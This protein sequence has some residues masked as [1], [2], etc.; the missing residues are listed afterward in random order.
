MK[1]KNNQ[2]LFITKHKNKTAAGLLNIG[3]HRETCLPA[4]RYPN[5]ELLTCQKPVA[6]CFSLLI[7]I[8]KENIITI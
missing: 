6:G 3:C 7:V 8:S 5:S 2:S 4:G 1:Q